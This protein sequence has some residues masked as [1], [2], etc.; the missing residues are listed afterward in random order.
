MQLTANALRKAF[1]ASRRSG[2]ADSFGAVLRLA[3]VAV[4][5]LSTIPD[6]TAQT[7]GPP[8]A[9]N[10]NA[11]SDAGTD[12]TPQVT[13]DLLGNWV[14]VWSSRDALG[15]TIGTDTDILVARST[16]A[17][18]TWTAPAALN[19]NAASD[20]GFD[21]RPQ[22]AT[23]GA[24]NWVA[25]WHSDDTLGGTI[26][27][28][29]DILVARSTDAGATWTAPAALNT[30]AASDAGTDDDAQV[31]TDLLGNWVAVWSGTIEGDFGILVARSTDA[32]ATW[33]AP[34]ALNTIASFAGSDPQVTT[35][36]A[37]RW[38]AVWD[39][40]RTIFASDVLV[41]HSTDAGATWTAPVVLN[42]NAVSGITLSPQVTTGGPGSWLAVWHSE[43]TLGGTIGTDSDIL[44]SIGCVTA[45]Q[46]QLDGTSQIGVV[47]S[48]SSAGQTFTVGRGGILNGLELSL[49]S[50]GTGLPPLVV[51]ILDVSGGISGAPVL[52]T[53]SV[54]QDQLGSMPATLALDS[55]TA[56]FVDLRHRRLS[57]SAG[58]QLAFRLSTAAVLPDRY[59]LRV[60]TTNLYAGGT[61]FANDVPVSGDVAF[62]TFVACGGVPVPS[63]SLPSH[64][65]IVLL[66]LVAGLLAASEVM[67]RRA[68]SVP[69]RS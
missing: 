17:G 15:G 20:A 42:P 6:A 16:D 58:D 68:P 19:T 24:G 51:E 50:V 10:T 37:G 5:A 12:E 31:T 2:A 53:V 18:A 61:G 21:R 7:F 65:L 8:R 44:A 28:D 22:L 11:A 67:R 60:Q 32:G 69:T 55:I 3:I 14:A 29:R 54:A 57:V 38:V 1:S 46:I 4:L 35:D 52:A 56:T 33:T 43:D 63:G 47:H 23:D 64:S 25:V 59:G 49:G 27:S 45:D 62:K 48:T 13:T 41:A 66:L 9:L 34:A 30:N 40:I 36:E 26:G 39:S